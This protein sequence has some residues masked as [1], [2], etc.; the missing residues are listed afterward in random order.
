MKAFKWSTPRCGVRRGVHWSM[1]AIVWLTA[2]AGIGGASLRANAQVRADLTDELVAEAGSGNTD[3]VNKLL[4]RDAVIDGKNNNGMTALM[5]AAANGNMDTI[6]LLV[7]K[8]ASL[9]ARDSNGFTAFTLACVEGHMEAAKLLLEKGADIKTKAQGNLTPL[10]LSAQVG[11][12]DVVRLLVQRGSDVN[13]KGMQGWTA[14]MVACRMGHEEVARVLI[15]NGAQVNLAN[16]LGA[17]PLMTAADRGY[18]GIVRLLLDNGADSELRNRN[19]VTALEFATRKRRSKVIGMLE[20][21]AKDRERRL[22]SLKETPPGTD[23]DASLPVTVEPEFQRVWRLRDIAHVQCP[24]TVV[25]EFQRHVP[26][27]LNWLSEDK[28]AYRLADSMAGVFGFELM[29]FKEFDLTTGAVRKLESHEARTKQTPDG[30]TELTVS[31]SYGFTW[32]DGKQVDISKHEVMRRRPV[33]EWDKVKELPG[34]PKCLDVSPCGQ[35]LAFCV[36]S[37]AC[38]ESLG[39]ETTFTME[40]VTRI[41]FGKTWHH[42]F[43]LK[44]DDGARAIELRDL[45]D[46][47]RTQTIVEDK[48]IVGFT[49]SADKTHLAYVSAV[50][51]GSLM[52]YVSMGEKA[53]LPISTKKSDAAAS[54]AF[55]PDQKLLAF[56]RASEGKASICTVH[57]NSL[58]RQVKSVTP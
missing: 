45:L 47:K 8:G 39:G 2:A 54:P 35:Y 21:Y 51:G 1:V 58:V 32:Q 5:A 42:V 50:E 33:E 17:T 3:R 56:V 37:K 43:V 24:V 22:A 31:S 49:V 6:R 27:E 9:E 38:I 41:C 4:E 30:R 46:S 44:T 29:A 57:V 14:L 16:D 26:V 40:G 36:E 19:G 13:H 20:N 25:R 28:I 48:T 34:E 18:E 11:Q 23:P 12:I 15:K 7:L 55:S 53:R 52:Y 10:I